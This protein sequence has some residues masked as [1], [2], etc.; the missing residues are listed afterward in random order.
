MVNKPLTSA[1]ATY[2]HSPWSAGD[3]YPN[4]CQMVPIFYYEVPWEISAYQV[5]VYTSY[6]FWRNPGDTED[7]LKARSKPW[8]DRFRNIVNTLAP[9]G[10]Y[11]Q[12]LDLMN[13]PAVPTTRISPTALPPP[14][15][16]CAVNCTANS[17]FSPDC[18]FCAN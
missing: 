13:A 3:K 14:G 15:G 5:G 12:M 16:K 11:F 2:L 18:N 1:E 8:E 10:A 9:K 6:S 17:T 7:M 4:N